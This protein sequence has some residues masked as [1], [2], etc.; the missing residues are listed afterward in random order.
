MHPADAQS[1]SNQNLWVRSPMPLVKATR[2]P[3]SV[4]DEV[5]DGRGLLTSVCAAGRRDFE[6]IR[7]GWG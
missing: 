6:A 7:D 5:R 2:A 3:P 4:C 1:V